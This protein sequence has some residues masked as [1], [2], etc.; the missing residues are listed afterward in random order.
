MLCVGGM[1]RDASEMLSVGLVHLLLL[2][3]VQLTGATV[4]SGSDCRDRV[5]VD[6]SDFVFRTIGDND[7]DDDN[8][9]NLFY[10]YYAIMIKWYCLVI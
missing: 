6:T 9:Q 7:E 1:H 2:L 4:Q 10:N 5:F 3:Q 8:N